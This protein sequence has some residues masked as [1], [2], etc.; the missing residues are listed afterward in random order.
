MTL[1]DEVNLLMEKLTDAWGS[2][3]V[4]CDSNQCVVSDGSEDCVFA[5]PTL[6]EALRLAEN[7]IEE[8]RQ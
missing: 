6:I 7:S 3:A 4:A 5:A 8:A 2:V 1:Y